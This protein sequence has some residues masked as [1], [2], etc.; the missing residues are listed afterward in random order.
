MNFKGSVNAFHGAFGVCSRY[1]Y[2]CVC[3]VYQTLER[4]VP[5]QQSDPRV[6]KTTM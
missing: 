3:V 6:H 5:K 2:V 4:H 1:I